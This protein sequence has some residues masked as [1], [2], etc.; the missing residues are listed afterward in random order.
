LPS[1]YFPRESYALREMTV[2]LPETVLKSLFPGYFTVTLSHC[3]GCQECQQIFVPSG[4]FLILKK[5]KKL[6]VAESG[7]ESGWSIFVMDFSASNM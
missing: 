2:P 6:Q 5:A 1:K 3:I 7:E 4:Y